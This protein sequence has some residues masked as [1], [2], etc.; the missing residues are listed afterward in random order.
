MPRFR[1]SVA[2]V[3]LSLL[4][5]AVAQAANATQCQSN[6]T[7][8]GAPPN[9]TKVLILGGGMAGVIAARTLQQQG[10]TDYVIVEAKHVFGGRMSQTTFGTNGSYVIEKGANWIH[11]TQTGSGPANPV[12]LLAKNHSL[13]MVESHL[14]TNITFFDYN[15]PNDYSATFNASLT[16][17]DNARALAG[18]RWQQNQTDL[19]LRSA[20]NYMGVSP[21]TPQ[22]EACEYYQIDYTDAYRSHRSLDAQDAS[23][24]SSLAAAWN[25]NYTFD[26]DVGYSDV[27]ML[28]VD[29]RGIA[30]IVQAEAATF[31]NT[32]QVL[33]NQTVKTI[34]YS[35]SG[36][37]VQTESGYTL[38]AD[39]ALV[40][41]SVGVLQGT[42]VSFE[43]A[44]PDWKR[45]AISNIEMPVYTKIFLQFEK[46]FWFDTEIGLYAD[47]QKGRYPVWQSL[48]YPGI[49]PG[50]GIIFVTVTGDY[51][52]YLEQLNKNTTQ[53]QLEVMEVLRRMYPNAPDPID[54]FLPVWGR[55]PL[56]RGSYSNWGASFRP[57]H[58]YELRAPVNGHL[59]FAG[60]GTSLKYFGFLQG[61]Y[62]EGE[63]AANN[64]AACIK[65]ST[66]CPST[67]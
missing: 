11:G 41:F 31:L 54:I 3:F 19:D 6:L 37:T 55:A 34:Q 65:N 35:Q 64:I 42:D 27:D 33:F 18:Q 38:S 56:F 39:H 14:F 17:F 52:N 53:V 13:Q 29:P 16:A 21:K 23:Q 67:S 40:T 59:W 45:V 61:A 58:S 12:W 9:S 48:D 51:A 43:P 47:Q 8:A 46:K 28:S 66:R 1:V 32:S 26:S 60:E 22:E 36:V 20:Y 24:T 10:I 2:A 15:G 49:Y 57:Q 5:G 25:Y 4:T 50:S 44:L 30:C 62:L 63:N 7:Q